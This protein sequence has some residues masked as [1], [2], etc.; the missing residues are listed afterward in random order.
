M[1]KTKADNLEIYFFNKRVLNSGLN[2]FSSAK[3][4]VFSMLYCTFL[5]LR[6]ACLLVYIRRHK[7]MVN[8]IF[9]L[10][11]KYRLKCIGAQ[12][13]TRRCQ[14]WRRFKYWLKDV[15]RNIC[16]QGIHD[17]WHSPTTK[18]VSWMTHQKPTYMAQHSKPWKSYII[19]K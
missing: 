3:L 10:M 17:D 16:Y 5:D 1:H 18:P 12:S 6:R 8:C 14:I 15:Q 7:N 9:Y 11:C 2:I 13:S 19:A 4:Q